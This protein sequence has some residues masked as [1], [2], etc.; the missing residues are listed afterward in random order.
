MRF[1]FAPIR[2]FKSP[3]LR[4]LTWASVHLAR[5]SGSRFHDHLLFCWAIVGQ[6][7]HA[8]LPWSRR[9]TNWEMASAASRRNQRLVEV[10]RHPAQGDAGRPPNETRYVHFT[11]ILS[12]SAF[13]LEDLACDGK[14]LARSPASRRDQSLA[15]AR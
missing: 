15:W 11:G 12:S 5:M 1:G 8:A 6:K 3:S 13:T 2:G 9:E 14:V 4:V 10:W 7:S